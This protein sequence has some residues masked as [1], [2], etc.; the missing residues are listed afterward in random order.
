MS[1]TRLGDITYL[2][3]EPSPHAFIGAHEVIQQRLD[4]LPPELAADIRA[5]PRDLY[6][7]MAVETAAHLAAWPPHGVPQWFDALPEAYRREAERQYAI[8]AT[9]DPNIALGFP[10]TR[11]GGYVVDLDE[12][13]MLGQ[14]YHLFRLQRLNFIRQLAWLTQP[15][16]PQDAHDIYPA[17]YEHNRL[18]H[19]EDVAAVANL[20]G[21]GLG[22][23]ETE[24]RTLTLAAMT[25]D[26]RTPAGGDTTKL[27][28][29]DYFDEDKHYGELL[30]R[31]GVADFLREFGIDAAFL[32]A[33]VQGEGLLG[34]L[35]D[36]ADKTAY[37]SRDAA[38][39]HYR[40]RNELADCPEGQA[41]HDLLIKRPDV[42]A[43]WRCAEVRG[44]K[45]V[46][47][48][49]EALAEM[50]RLRALLFRSLYF[51][52]G[53]RYTEWI[54]SHIVLRHLVKSGEIRKE[55]LLEWNDQELDL[56]VQRYTNFGLGSVFGDPVYE[57]FDDEASAEARRTELLADNENCVTIERLPAK[58]GSGTKFLVLG[59][60]KRKPLPL[61]EAYPELAAPVDALARVVQPYRLYWVPTDSLPGRLRK[62]FAD[63]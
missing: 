53:A 36:L 19:V 17:R 42:C 46:L 15:V 34:T 22:L 57:G 7:R 18:S 51:H 32:T 14:A 28:D 9:E 59:P 54:V 40:F 63:T 26:A 56:H 25:H 45:L 58:I 50:L 12:R 11:L 33:T 24:V 10:Y 39:F 6:I 8:H 47:R 16:L 29:R 27:L 49:P 31:D 3:E 52:P 30:A 55:D 43:A 2:P 5:H 61:A 20:L 35:L 48:D 41:V 38:S 21:H 44:G 4:R 1:A 13:G 60:R 37:L 62:F 23:S